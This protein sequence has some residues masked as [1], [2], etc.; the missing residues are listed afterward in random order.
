[1]GQI[2]A[3]STAARQASATLLSAETQ[4]SRRYSAMAFKLGM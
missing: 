2:K 3:D 1:M 4:I